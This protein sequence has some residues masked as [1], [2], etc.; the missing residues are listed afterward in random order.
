[1][2]GGYTLYAGSSGAAGQITFTWTVPINVVKNMV[3][4]TKA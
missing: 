2:G 3:T 4:K 1:M